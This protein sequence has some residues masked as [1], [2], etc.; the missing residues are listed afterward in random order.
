MLEVTGHALVQLRVAAAEEHEPRS[1][2]PGEERLAIHVVEEDRGGALGRLVQ[3]RGGEG[4]PQQTAGVGALAVSPQVFRESHPER[5]LAEAHGHPQ[6]ERLPPH[7]PRQA[8]AEEAREQVQRCRQR[9]AV[10]GRPAAI[11]HVVDVQIVLEDEQV[12]R[13]RAAEE[14]ERGGVGPYHQV[15]PVVDVLARHRIAIGRRA[16]AEHPAALEQGDLVAALLQVHGGGEPGEAGPD[17]GDLHGRRERTSVRSAIQAL[18]GRESC[19][20]SARG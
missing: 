20:R 10:Q 18:R 15:R 3:D 14:V 1:V 5:R 8:Q 9:R 4:I 16:P 19:T 6:A 7:R 2:A 17:D 11:V 13:A 12:L